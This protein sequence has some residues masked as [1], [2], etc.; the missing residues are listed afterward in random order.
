MLSHTPIEPHEVHS[1]RLMRHARQ[2]LA[3]DDRPQASEKMWGAFSH[4]LKA[5]VDERPWAYT[6]HGQVKAIVEALA[7]ESDAPELQDEAVF[8][9]YLHLNY[10]RDLDRPADIARYHGK[11]ESALARLREIRRRYAEDAD[12]RRQADALRPPH[13]RYDVRRRR[14][15]HEPPAPAPAPPDTDAVPPDDGRAPPQ[16]PNPNGGNPG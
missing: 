1:E 5:V 7:L 4:G 16:P 10:Y 15:L 14:W 3:K 6:D 11:V 2:E 8:A 12:Y 9:H 13:S